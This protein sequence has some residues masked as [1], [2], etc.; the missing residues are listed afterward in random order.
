MK[1]ILRILLLTVT[2]AQAD[3]QFLLRYDKPASEFTSDQRENPNQLGY[4]Q[5]ALPLG[6]GRLGAMFSGGIE[7]EHLMINDI[8]LWM[9]SQRGL[10]E[11]AQSG[12]RIGAYKDF[13]KVREVYRQGHYGSSDY[14]MEAI[15]TK[16]LSTTQTLG[17]YAPF[18]DLYVSSG[19][20]RAA[21]SDYIR[22]LDAH[23][24]IGTVSYRIGE[25]QFE[26]EY[27]CSHPNDV[28]VVRY[29]STNSAMDLNI[30][31][32]RIDKYLLNRPLGSI[33][34]TTNDANRR[35]VFECYLGNLVAFNI[36]ISRLGHFLAGRQIGP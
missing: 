28:V 20:D 17:N 30:Q 15:S 23:S 34:F 8:T 22:T 33:G 1:N 16:Y 10:D 3:A 21:V 26:R 11:V 9:N 27:F 2:Y 31:V 13:E 29:T 25:A 12:V 14:S 4:M 6:N 36:S 32:S 7:Q 5:E 18:T 19:H 24:G 35:S